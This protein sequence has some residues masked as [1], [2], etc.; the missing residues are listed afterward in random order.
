MKGSEVLDR[1]LN[2]LEN[3]TR[4]G[5][6]VVLSL[7][8]LGT[9]TSNGIPVIGCRCRACTSVDPRDQRTRCSAVLHIGE[10]VILIDTAPELRLQA[11]RVGLTR[12]D[13]ILFTHAHADHVAGFD[14]LRQF[15]LLAQAPL[16]VFADPVTARE[17][18]TRFAYAFTDPLPFYG[19]KPELQLHE[20]S[21]PFALFG[22]TITPI[23]VQHGAWTVYGFR[24]GPLAYVTDAKTIPPG[25]RDLLRGIDVLVLN[26]LR[27]RPHPTHLSLAEALELVEELQPKRTYLTHVSHEVVHAE[28]SQRLPSGVS[29]AYDGLRIWV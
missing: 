21:G 17:L 1:P 28:W 25:S 3:G 2:R 7:T 10:R 8:F 27:E 13:A 12:L 23:P 4:F 29:L 19:G 14:D 9:G 11:L 15:N 16:P 6:Q 18:K 22:I 20:F 5:L 24:F 26:A